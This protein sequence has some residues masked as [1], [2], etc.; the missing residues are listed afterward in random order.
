MI[1]I[2]NKVLTDLLLVRQIKIMMFEN[3]LRLLRNYEIPLWFIETKQQESVILYFN[4]HIFQFKQ[5]DIVIQPTGS[6][7]KV[8]VATIAKM[9]I[10]AKGKW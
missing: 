8:L 6:E 1:A 5:N 10:Y 9:L 3:A 7:V 4:Y 2:D